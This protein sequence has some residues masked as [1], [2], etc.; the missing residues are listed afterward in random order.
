MKQTSEHGQSNIKTLGDLI[1][2]TEVRNQL[3]LHNSIL[4]IVIS[5]HIYIDL[6]NATTNRLEKIDHSS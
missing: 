3:L 5:S 1:H 4:D 6:S 2:S